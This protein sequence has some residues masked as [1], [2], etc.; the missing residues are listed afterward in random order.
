MPDHIV[1]RRHECSLI[2]L[3]DMN[4]LF[5]RH[6]KANRR[7]PHLRGDADLGEREFY[8]IDFDMMVKGSIYKRRS[9]LIRQFGVTVN[10][11]TRLVTSGDTVDRATYRALL[12][13][14]A[15]RTPE[16]TPAGSRG[17]GQDA[18]RGGEP[19]LPVGADSE[20]DRSV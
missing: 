4:V 17:S 1:R 15:L 3:E 12:K 7:P 8:T 13:A 11:A 10:G 14:G 19:S 2:L 5:G 16:E 18:R 6:G 9:G 20:T